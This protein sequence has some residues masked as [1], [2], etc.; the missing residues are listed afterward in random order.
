MVAGSTAVLSRMDGGGNEGEPPTQTR[1]L[2]ARP[3]ACL[4]GRPLCFLPVA[5]QHLESLVLISDGGRCRRSAAHPANQKSSSRREHLNTDAPLPRHLT[6]VSHHLIPVVT[7][8]FQPV[9]GNSKT[10]K[11]APDRQTVGLQID[12]STCSLSNSE[13]NQLIFVADSMA[14]CQKEAFCWRE[15]LRQLHVSSSCYKGNKEKHVFPTVYLF[16]YSF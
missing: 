12:L 9:P 4:P 3:P 8:G 6:A 7:G 16:L 1:R 13:L 5:E 10:S 15:E 14:Y 11:R 2:P